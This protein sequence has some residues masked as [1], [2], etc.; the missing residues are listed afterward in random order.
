MVSDLSRSGGRGSASVTRPIVLRL[1]R[2]L[3]AESGVATVEFCM[4]LPILMF[5]ILLLV[6]STLLM[7]GN[8]YVHY[9]AFAATRSAIV[10][11]PQ[12]YSLNGE[13]CNEIIPEEGFPKFDAIRASAYLAVAPV[14]GR[15]EDSSEELRAEQYADGLRD[16][17]THYGRDVP[18]WVD[19]L[20][21]DRLR[22]AAENT[23]VTILLTD[24]VDDSVEFD[25]TALLTHTFGPREPITVLV[26][27][28]LNLSV[29]YV[30]AL[31]ADGD[32]DG[33][34]R[35]ALVTAQYTLTNEG[36]NPYL[37]DRPEIPREER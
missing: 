27:H 15:L 18:R 3:R 10:Y 12:D 29:P 20:A 37:P 32:L 4:V 25:D 9:A 19:T 34:G 21:A 31:F 23:E 13:P 17:F 14:C 11:I 36:V 26:E 28:K 24:V 6:Q 16:Y 33:G 22:Y 35:Y 7:V 1:R 8:Q 30:R 2:A 5:L